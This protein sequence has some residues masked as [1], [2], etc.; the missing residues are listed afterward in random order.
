MFPSPAL[1]W[2]FYGLKIVVVVMLN[3]NVYLYVGMGTNKSLDWWVF[4]PLWTMQ[5]YSQELHVFVSHMTK[6]S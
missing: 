2:F 4:P 6:K 3:I 5:Y 1:T